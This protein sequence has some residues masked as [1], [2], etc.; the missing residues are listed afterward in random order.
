MLCY[1]IFKSFYAHTNNDIRYR[2][3][4]IKAI[5]SEFRFIFILS[6]VFQSFWKPV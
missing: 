6:T 1:V 5:E 3:I 2:L 4:D